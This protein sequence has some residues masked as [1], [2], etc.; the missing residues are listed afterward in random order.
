MSLARKFWARTSESPGRWSD[1]FSLELFF[2]HEQ[3]RFLTLRAI[4]SDVVDSAAASARADMEK[5]AK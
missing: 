5:K 3:H 2:F 1:S 4:D